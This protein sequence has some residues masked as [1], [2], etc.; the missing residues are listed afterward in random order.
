M[1]KSDCRSEELQILRN[2]PGHLLILVFL[3]WIDFD[4]EWRLAGWLAGLLAEYFR[5]LSDDV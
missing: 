4:A 1:E 5:V 2:A 3:S